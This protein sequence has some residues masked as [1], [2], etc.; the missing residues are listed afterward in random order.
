[1][2]A[3]VRVA[4][5]PQSRRGWFVASLLYE[6]ITRN[7]LWINTLKHVVICGIHMDMTLEPHLK[8]VMG[9][10][11]LGRRRGCFRFDEQEVH[12]HST[13]NV[14]ET[15][16]SRFLMETSLDLRIRRWGEEMG[17]PFLIPL[18]W[19]RKKKKKL[20]RCSGEWLSWGKRKGKLCGMRAYWEIV[21]V[22]HSGV[23]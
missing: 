12:M 23:T 18:L 17:S 22:R 4:P 21:N 3:H 2:A 13:K 20:T 15:H 14:N 8:G 7:W 16:S 1:M 11:R 9:C 19:K 6:G 10:F 5:V